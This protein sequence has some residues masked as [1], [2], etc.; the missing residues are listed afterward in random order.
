MRALVTG[1]AGFIGSHLAEA[2]LKR[3]D[4]VVVLDD[5]STGRI[6]NITHLMENPRFQYRIDTVVNEYVV[7]EL[8]EKC[9]I[10]FHLAAA[11]GVKY[12]VENPL[13]AIL[14][15]I[16]GA[17][18]ILEQASRFRRKAIV[19]ST[20]EVYGKGNGNPLRESDD[21]VLGPTE[22]TR[23]NYATS[24]AVDEYLAFAYWQQ[25]GLPVVIVRCFN[26]CGPRQVGDYGM[27]IPRFINQA[28]S[29]EP[30]TVHGDGSQTRCFSYVG[31]VV[32]GVLM[33]ASHPG[34]VGGVF[35]IGTDEEVTIEY[36]AERVRR[37]TGSNSPIQHIP[38]EKVYGGRFED[39][40][41]RV[42]DLKK[43]SDL[44]GYRPQVTLDELLTETIEYCR[45]ERS[46][47]GMTVAAAV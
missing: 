26:T 9:D 22:V 28:L 37:L 46:R 14:T 41:R 20:S 34:A 19:F 30:L 47:L 12:V 16:R 27:V 11:V 39:L 15:N 8:V 33:L 23:W 1:G 42:P 4:Q 43:I 32:R 25:N 3:G 18:V 10:V 45:A 2:L 7:G 35:N 17:E 38:Y 40:R 24:K 36:L 5:L 21:R 31:D 13:R 6:E 29:S 44:I